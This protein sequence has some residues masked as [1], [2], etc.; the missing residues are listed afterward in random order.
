M[1]FHGAPL[2]NEARCRLTLIEE[3]HEPKEERDID[4][5]LSIQRDVD[6][7]KMELKF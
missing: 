7:V 4:Y 6:D 2:K 3:S 5:D 1:V